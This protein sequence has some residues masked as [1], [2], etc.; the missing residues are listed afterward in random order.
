[1]AVGPEELE[2]IAANGRN[3]FQTQIGRRRVADF[4]GIRRAAHV[5]MT[6]FT[7]DTGA[8]SPQAVEG[9]GAFVVVIPDNK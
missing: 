9:V 2:G 6:P 5:S 8:N 4:S 3:L 1:M 7:F